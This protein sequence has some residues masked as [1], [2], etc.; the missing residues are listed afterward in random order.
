MVTEQV[1]GISS[2]GRQTLPT[3]KVVFRGYDRDAV[4]AYLRRSVPCV[5]PSVHVGTPLGGRVP[6]W[7]G[8]G[9]GDDA[10]D[11]AGAADD[12]AEAVDDV[13]YGRRSQQVSA[14]DGAGPDHQGVSGEAMQG[15][16]D[17]SGSTQTRDSLGTRAGSDSRGHSGTQGGDQPGGSDWETVAPA[18]R[19]AGESGAGGDDLADAKDHPGRVAGGADAQRGAGLYDAAPEL[20][21]RARLA[22]GTADHDRAELKRELAEYRAEKTKAVRREVQQLMSDVADLQRRRIALQSDIDALSE[23]ANLEADR[24]VSSAR[25][26]ATA[27]VSEAQQRALDMLAAPQMS[28]A[29]R[30]AFNAEHA[31]NMLMLEEVLRAFNGR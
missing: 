27:I 31:K 20:S 22:G 16:R 6:V 9:A 21:G 29:A 19:D 14:G 25:T 3:F 26:K 18:E 2:G 8:H 12:V 5:D 11:S 24:V 4:D 23:K 1:T 10:D 7:P 13:V 30:E 28:E 17:D 15:L